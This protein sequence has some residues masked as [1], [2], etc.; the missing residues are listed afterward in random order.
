MLSQ[1]A[2]LGS[3]FP[4]KLNNLGTAPQRPGAAFFIGDCGGV[5]RGN[6]CAYANSVS[7]RDVFLRYGLSC[8]SQT[9]LN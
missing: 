2:M 9:N 7:L 8:K 3:K 1:E 4:R 6:L 5:K